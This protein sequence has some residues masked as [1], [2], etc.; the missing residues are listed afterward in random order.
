MILREPAKDFLPGGALTVGCLLRPRR[1]GKGR[2]FLGDA[3]M[4]TG[5]AVAASMALVASG[6]APEETKV[7]IAQ[8]PQAVRDTIQRELVGAE[9]EDIAKKTV[10]G[11]VVYETD[12]IRNGRKWEVVIREDGTILSKLQEELAGSAA[13]DESDAG[14]AGPAWRDRFD[15]NNADL[16]PTGTNAYITMQPGRVLRLKNGIDTLTITVLPETQEID[17]VATGVLEERETK[18]GTLAEISRNFFA[19]D[20]K[21]GDVYYF[22][23]DVDNYKD[24]KVVSH[25]SAWRAGTGG[26]RFGL[27]IPATPTVG[28]A[29]YQEI[30][31]KVAMDRVEVVSTS[32]TVKT[33]AGTFERCVHLR[34]TTP[35]ESDVSHKYLAPGIGLIKDDEFEL[36]ERPQV[37]R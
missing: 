28:Q 32:A 37:D 10:D 19:T 16:L 11:Q 22:G 4:T 7:A 34:E 36:A 26:A 24:G 14:Q 31:P 9:L 23:E 6:C 5:W 20:R 12:I 2:D 18:N 17:G 25:E 33:P 8:T 29:F 3:N 21:T 15:V 30:A 13:A 1:T 35:L 27:M